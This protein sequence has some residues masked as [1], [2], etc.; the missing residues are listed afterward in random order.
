VENLTLQIFTGKQ[1]L[2]EHTYLFAEVLFNLFVIHALHRDSSPQFLKFLINH[3]LSGP[4]IVEHYLL[5]V[6]WS[7]DI[8][9]L[10]LNILKRKKKYKDFKEL[11]YL[12][13]QKGL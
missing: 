8:D 13:L 2:Q 9:D 12:V 6:H 3:K 10:I 7:G 1:S 4:I 11:I 5:L